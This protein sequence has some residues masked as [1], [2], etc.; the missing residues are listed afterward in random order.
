MLYDVLCTAG[1]ELYD[2][3][4]AD[5]VAHANTLIKN[6]KSGEMVTI[7]SFSAESIL[8][9]TLKDGAVCKEVVPSIPDYVWDVDGAGT[10]GFN[11][12][13]SNRSY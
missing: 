1:G 6:L 4:K 13:N 12:G 3:S 7:S 5:A 9:I 10:T 8:E 11:G 2:V